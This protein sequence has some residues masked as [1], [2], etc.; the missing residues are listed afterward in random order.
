MQASKMKKSGSIAARRVLAKRGPGRPT[1]GRI[2]AINQAL[3]V[4][5]RTEFHRSG[6][7]GTRVDTIAA[8]AGV[9]KATLY[10]RYPTKEAL[11]RAVVTDGTT[12]WLA[13]WQPDGDSAPS[14]VRQRLKYR[15]RKLMRWYCSGKLEMLER[16]FSSGPSMQELRRMRHE[17]GHMRIVQVM[18]QDII[19]A[20]T[21]HPISPESAPLIAEML[22]A[23]L[24]GWWAAQQELG[25]VKLE[26]GLAYADHAV[27]VLL[28]GRSAWSRAKPG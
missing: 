2:E 7:E 5:A 4:A 27:D 9:S 18:V 6:Y 16:L 12:T 20:S 15:A 28:D 19:D 3:L 13:S 14:D 17:V 21:D 11:L 22:M 26:D 1:A 10:D 8:M 25:P 24:A 23:M